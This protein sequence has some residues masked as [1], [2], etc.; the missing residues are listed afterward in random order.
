MAL[1]PSLLKILVCPVDKGSLLYFED[2]MTL[3]NPRLRRRYRVNGNVPDMLADHAET[4]LEDEH[5]RILQRAANG[6]AVPTQ[7]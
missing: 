3:Y 6:R 5:A 7:R 4:V 1:D 2:D